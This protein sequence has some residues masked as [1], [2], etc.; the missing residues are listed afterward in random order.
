MPA[1]RS[2]RER[3]RTDQ[4]PMPF[5]GSGR[6]G[7]SLGA[8]RRAAIDAGRDAPGRIHKL[9]GFVA[10]AQAQHP[11]VLGNA[12]KDRDKVGAARAGEAS[13]HLVANGVEDETGSELD[14]ALRPALH[15]LGRERRDRQDDERGPGQ[16]QG[17]IDEGRIARVAQTASHCGDDLC[18]SD[19][20]RLPKGYDAA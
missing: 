5:R 15:N 17:R 16:G 9:A 19:R 6:E 7:V 2:C 12:F 11:L 18:P 13:H 1:D 10:K 3:E 8:H 14:I 20:S 4:Q